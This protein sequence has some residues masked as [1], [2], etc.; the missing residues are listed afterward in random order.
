MPLPL[1]VLPEDNT[2]ICLTI[3]NSPQ[4]RQI[5][6]GALQI[7]AQWWYWQVENP[8]DAQDVVQ[9]VMECAAITGGNYE[10]CMELDCNDVLD[11]IE[12]NE[13]IQ[14]AI[15]NYAM[16]SN[17]D[18]SATENA[19]NLA[20]QLVNNPDGCDD[21]IIYGMTLQLV[22][23]SD[24]LI[25]DFFEQ[26]KASQ[27]A[28][29]NV[30]YIIKLIPVVETLP[31]DELF[32]LT[33]KLTE[34]M[35]AAYLSASTTLLKTEIACELFCIA[36]ENDCTL[37]LELVRDYFVEK[38]NKTFSYDSFLTFT[39]DF[40]S[41]V[42]VG[43]AVYYAM[44]ILFFQIFVFGGSWI[45]YLWRDYLRVINAMYND[46]NSDWELECDDCGWVHTFDFLVSD[47]GWSAVNLGYGD[48]GAWENGVGWVSSDVQTNASF[49][50][51][52]ILIDIDI[53]DTEISS[54][55][56]TYEFSKGTYDIPSQNAIQ[57]VQWLDSGVEG[58]SQ[59][60]FTESSGGTDL[61][62]GLVETNISDRLTMQVRSS[63]RTTPVYSG[64]A[65][66]TRCQVRGFGVNPF[67]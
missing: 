36:R 60:T 38:A 61:E 48:F 40:I 17:I 2:E 10:E 51:R 3:P 42:F 26:V 22:E 67:V 34:E 7:M 46:P 24:R 35:E 6:M 64:G 4:W 58:A 30:G 11:C 54:I 8:V 65:V 52:G 39:A 33:T 15:A 62:F 12:T 32:E 9:R 14:R 49:Y 47:G 50:G 25:K 21:D 57:L 29:N 31:I 23:F 28:S 45:E 16:T 43:N 18:S 41:G 37:T 19:S 59:L 44:N 1:P 55:E 63:S 5:Y 13:D 56:M 66:I 20:G 27:S 53:A